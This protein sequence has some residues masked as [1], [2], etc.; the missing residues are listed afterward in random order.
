MN[1]LQIFNYQEKQVRTVVKDG[2][3]WWVA[4]DVCEALTL[5]NPT[6]A[7]KALDD[8]EKSTLRISEGGPEANIISEAGLYSLIIRSNK[9][10][11]K[12][13]KRWI[14][15]EVL[16]SI[17]KT[18]SY[19]I[20]GALRRADAMLLNAK[21][22]QANLMKRMAQEFK[23]QLSPESI[24][25]LLAGATE[26]LMGKPL[27]PKPQIGVTFMATEIAE[28]TGV[29]ANKVG[30]VSNKYNLKTTEYG[31]WVLDKSQSSDKQVKTF[32]YNE[33]GRQVLID[34]IE[35]EM[36]L[37]PMPASKEANQKND[38]ITK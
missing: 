14:T 32:V 23:D 10:E 29:S 7:V 28:E 15:H 19:E 22:R 9:P 12:A 8:D 11:A 5:T 30:R 37:A 17:R 4:K 36:R 20:P 21:I 13:F 38:Q 26:I 6:E 33:I 2:E 1:N 27:L 18:G 24:Q 31:M 25:L 34:A 16:P 3:P 35:K